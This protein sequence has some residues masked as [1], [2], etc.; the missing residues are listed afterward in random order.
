IMDYQI[1]DFLGLI[2][3]DV[4]KSLSPFIHST[5][6]QKRGQKAYYKA[7]SLSKKE[8]LTAFKALA[9][10]SFKGINITNPYK[11]LAFKNVD[12]LSKSAE[13]IGAINTIKV[14]EDDKL[15]GYNTD[16]LAVKEILK[17]KYDSL[18]E[19]PP[20]LLLGAGGA[21]RA[22]LYALLDL[23]FKNLT[24]ANR[25]KAKA[26]NLIAEFSKY[27]QEKAN[28]QV[29]EWAEADIARAVV[30]SEIIIDATGLSW[31]NKT[32][33]GFNRISSDNFIFD[34]SYPDFKSKLQIRAK[35]VEADYIDG[36]KMLLY[37]AREADQIWFPE[38]NDKERK[39]LFDLEL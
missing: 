30:D 35:K 5:V 37:Q 19:F 4:N 13:E 34:L 22:V 12:I 38:Y 31:S 9:I 36:R 33:P 21:A 23:G 1:Q 6:Y 26:V 39:K 27:K 28:I 7:Y 11:E 2:G 18:K 16:F 15:K 32:F 24:I 3:S 25:T 10:F 20:V 17:D 14:M 8:A 29:I